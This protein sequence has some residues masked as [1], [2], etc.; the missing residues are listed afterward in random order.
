MN[1]PA[2]VAAP[3]LPAVPN[4]Q[5]LSTTPAHG[6]ANLRY[7]AARYFTDMEIVTRWDDI[8]RSTRN[9]PEAKYAR[10]D[11]YALR[12]PHSSQSSLWGKDSFYASALQEEDRIV[13]GRL[14]MLI[15][16]CRVPISSEGGVRVF[17]E[18]AKTLQNI[19]S[20]LLWDAAVDM[21]LARHI[22]NEQR[23]I[24]ASTITDRILRKHFPEN[25][26]Y[27]VVELRRRVLFIVDVLSAVYRLTLQDEAA[28]RL[29]ASTATTM[30]LEDMLA[31]LKSYAERYMPT[32]I[33]AAPRQRFG[34]LRPSSR[35]Q[36]E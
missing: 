25:P 14:K 31:W 35:S 6:I 22:Q 16:R 11:L 30:Q 21:M 10:S 13:L 27:E 36:E 32:E 12:K 18:M 4:S 29:N 33:K 19:G 20:A 2:T 7:R 26:P 17:D 34:W 24:P 28:A 3:S 23:F 9:D 15:D 5:S 1:L 8:V